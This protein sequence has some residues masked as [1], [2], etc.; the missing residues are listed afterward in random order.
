LDFSSCLISGSMKQC[1]VAYT[2]AGRES[3]RE[4]GM[5]DGRGNGNSG[6]EKL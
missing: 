1:P 2:W 3:G 6:R 4:A 5:E